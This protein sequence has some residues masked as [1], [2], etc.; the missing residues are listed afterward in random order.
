MR[1]LDTGLEKLTDLLVRMGK[2]AGEIVALSLDGFLR[3]TDVGER[4]HSESQALA[5]MGWDVED[6][7]F[8]LIARYQPVASDLR[9]IKSYIKI[10]YDFERY[11]RYAWDI[12]LAQKQFGGLGG[13]VHPWIPIQKMAEKV[14][15]MVYTSTKALKEHNAEVA[16]TLATTEKEVDDMYFKAMDLLAEKIPTVTKSIISN[17]LVARYLERIADHAVYVGE[18]IVYIATGERILLR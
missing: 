14:M 16:K 7:A 17:L 3:G 9:I 2:T 12:C 6:K 18:S 11:G 1:P 13:Q 10:A 8:E 4:V 15:E 5:A